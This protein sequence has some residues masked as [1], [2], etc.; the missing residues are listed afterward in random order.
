[1][2]FYGLVPTALYLLLAV[3]SF[4][5]WRGLP[6]AAQGVA[7]VVTAGL[8][9]CIRNEWDLVTWPAPRPDSHDDSA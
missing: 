2:W 4:A 8:V 9:L 3:V 5:A 6:W 1:M 7:A